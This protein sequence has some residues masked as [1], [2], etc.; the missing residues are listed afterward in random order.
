MHLFCFLIPASLSSCADGGINS[1]TAKKLYSWRVRT[2]DLRNYLQMWS[3]SQWM[4]RFYPKH[5]QTQHVIAH[6]CL[7]P[8]S[9]ANHTA[10]AESTLVWG[11]AGVSTQPQ[12]VD[13]RRFTVGEWFGRWRQTALR[14]S[15]EFF[16]QP[17]TGFAQNGLK[18]DVKLVAAMLQKCF[19]DGKK[20][21]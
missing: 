1:S 16:V 17:S 2:T 5:N 15:K 11:C 9:N 21:T 6:T 20:T 19:A 18:N 13:G 14:I 7:I 8:R 4:N 10:A 3:F 12:N